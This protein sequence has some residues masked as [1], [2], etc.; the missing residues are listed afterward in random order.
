[1]GSHTKYSRNMQSEH[2]WLNFL[3][4]MEIS[5]MA[6]GMRQQ[7]GHSVTAK[8]GGAPVSAQGCWAVRLLFCLEG[9]RLM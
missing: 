5:D 1:M 8:E 7:A 3:E 9:M 6:E 2:A 4:P